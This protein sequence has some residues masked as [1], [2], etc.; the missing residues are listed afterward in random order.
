MPF[1]VIRHCIVCE[2]VRIEGL[3]K[4]SILGFYG[5]TP[6]VNLAIQDL[7]KPVERLSFLL[8]CESGE[9][10]HK[11]SV[12]IEGP[13]GERILATPEADF[14]FPSTLQPVN[15]VIAFPPVQ[16]PT[17]GQHR[18]VL[19]VQGIEQ[20]HTTLEIQQGGLSNIP[21]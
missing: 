13:R 18:F 2:E 5:I 11:V 16:F 19:L 7:T 4:S 15:I 8:I 10:N 6:N 3:G 21:R 20:F 17:V 14:S 9:G 12:K 1:P